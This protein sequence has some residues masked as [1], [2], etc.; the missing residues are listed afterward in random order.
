MKIKK[1]I[2]TEIKE[3]Q[4]NIDS[5][6][7]SFP[8]FRIEKI[9]KNISNKIQKI[10]GHKTFKKIKLLGM[11][12]SIMLFFISFNEAKNKKTDI[13]EKMLETAQ[14][15][16]L[17]SRKEKIAIKIKIILRRTESF[18]LTGKFKKNSLL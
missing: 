2:K 14:A 7:F 10:Y 11:F 13:D 3:Q 5:A 16:Y 8:F 12:S 18:K 9:A 6:N 4:K 15:I 1:T 17:L